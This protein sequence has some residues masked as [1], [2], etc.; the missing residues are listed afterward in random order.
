MDS[1]H[2]SKENETCFYKPFVQ[3]KL[4]F[5]ILQIKL[6]PA[7]ENGKKYVIIWFKYIFK[8]KYSHKFTF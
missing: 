7:T 4:I 5:Q 1:I 2:A 8:V 3:A 6:I